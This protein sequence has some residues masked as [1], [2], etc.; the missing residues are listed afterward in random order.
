[1]GIKCMRR[2]SLATNPCAV[3]NVPSDTPSKRFS[4]TWSTA[5]YVAALV[6]FI[7]APLGVDGLTGIGLVEIPSQVGRLRE[8][9]RSDVG[10]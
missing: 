1:M 6:G 7:C 2:P 4:T 3:I 8:T 9:V 5:M 10:A